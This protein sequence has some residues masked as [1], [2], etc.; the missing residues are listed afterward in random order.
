MTYYGQDNIDQW[1]VEHCQLPEKGV[2]VDVGAGDGINMSNSKHLEEKG[3][4]ALCLDADPRVKKSLPTNRKHGYS[5]LISN[6]TAKQ[7]FY[8]NDKTPDISGIIKTEGNKDKTTTLYPMK[9]EH[10]LEKEKIKKIDILSIDTEGTEIDVFES[11]EWEKHKP[12]YLVIEFDTQG[13][14]NLDIEPYFTAKGYKVIGVHGPNMIFELPTEIK[15]DPH[16]IVYGSSYDR[17]LD[18][19]LNMWP[20]IKKAVPDARL[21]VFYGWN[22]YD[23]GYH[24]N[25]E[26]MAWK[27][28]INKLM[29]QDGIT[30]LGRISHGAVK[31]EFELAGVWAYPTYFGEI[32]CITAMKAQAYGAIPVVVDYAA[33][34]E[35]VQYGVKIKGDIYDKETKDLYLGALIA[36]LNDEKHQETI[37]PE[38]IEWA[39]YFE[40]KNVANQWNDE[41]KREITPE[42][43]AMQLI[44]ADEPIEAL[45]LLNTDSPLREKLVG[46]LDH[47]FNY[48]K[49]KEKYANDPMNWKPEPH[50]DANHTW[51]LDEAKDAKTLIDL[52]CYEGSLVYRFGEGAI[53]VEMCKA[54]VKHC[55][56]QKINVVEGDALTYQDGKK[57]DVVSA[58]E[59][60]EHVPDPKVLVDN[61]LSLVSDD[62]WCYIVTPNGAF[63]MES[64]QK[65]WNDK[66]ALIDHVRTY[67]I[68]KMQQLLAGCDVKIAINDKQI[69]AKFRRNL[70]RQVEELLENNQAIQAWELVKDTNW[71]KKDR[72]WLRVKHA[73]DPE[74]YYKYYSEDLVETPVSEDT[75]LDCTKLYPRFRWLVESIEKQKARSLTDL[76]CAD[77]YLCLTIAKRLGILCYG[78][79]LFKPSINIA[80]ERAEKFDLP[81][82][83]ECKDLMDVKEEGAKSDAV[84]L[85]EVLEHLPDPQKAIDHCMSLVTKGGS[86]YLTTP[87]PEHIGIKL[88]KEEHGRQEGDW[89]DGLPSGHLRIFTE[90]QLRELLGKYKIVQ[91]LTDEQ[92][93]FLIEVRNN[94]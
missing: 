21:R 34:K 27:E 76:G 1:I 33:L 88:H 28:K 9:L 65:V 14:V 63:N 68:E 47:I 7:T 59:I 8:M 42:E 26:R 13:T 77:G 40:W 60:I 30:H 79:N 4:L 2:I 35:T 18:I 6:K 74:A 83:F 78:I 37:R 89:N 48:E 38:M 16:L 85:S 87:S 36:L 80:K 93:C 61:M 19:L 86:F 50:N 54:A 70:D 20:E 5:A 24:D 29:E 32:S 66:D 73:Y 17:G 90:Q 45:K 82:A 25:P 92:G 43:K 12:T 58:C 57:Y 64:T 49:Y 39:K 56:D 41:F 46:K 72:L 69:A 55:Q 81:C 84:V 91:F 71:P 10:Y 51:I 53:G 22:L 75:S 44:L 15:R 52:G 23:V 3:W 11:M 67:N 62:G 94:D 31:R